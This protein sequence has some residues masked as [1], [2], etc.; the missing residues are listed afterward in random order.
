MTHKAFPLVSKL[1]GEVFNLKRFA[2]PD[3]K[4]WSFFNPSIG[5]SPQ[6]YA[7]TFRS[8]NYVINPDSGELY[9]ETGGPIKNKVFFTETN[10][11]MELLD[12]REISFKDSGL[13]VERGVEDTKLFW[14]HNKWYFSGVVMERHTP[15]ARMGIFTLDPKKN[16]A[17]LDHIYKGQSAK[18]PEKNWMIPYEPNPNFDFIHGP[19][20]VGK[21]AQILFTASD[22]HKIAPLRGN[23][24]LLTLDDG[25]YL[26]VVHILYTRETRT[27]DA[28]MFGMRDGKY[29]NYT[30][31][32]AQYN[33]RGKL[34]GLSQEFQFVSPGIEFANGLVQMG[35]DLVITFGKDDVSSH[36]CKIPKWKAL[37]MLV[38][39]DD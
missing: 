26:A 2:Y 10:K 20:S 3:D 38:A 24:N 32:F 29:K 35:D 30:H 5:Q 31:L 16:T 4:S 14:R 8:S 39:V 23:T 9:V 15:I 1:G 6:G 36:Y 33:T 25:T 19:T 21:G 17:K 27:W 12:I 11:N 7:M 13:I 22:N 18:K 37:K 34:I 28:R